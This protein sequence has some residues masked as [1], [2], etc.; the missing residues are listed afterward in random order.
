MALLAVLEFGDN[1]TKRYYKQYLLTDLR[2]MFNR[3]YNVIP[4]GKIRCEG[5]E[6]TVVA[7]Y[8]NDLS[9]FEWFL[10]NSTHSGRIVISLTGDSTDSESKA[11]EIYFEDAKCASLSEKYQVDN[12]RNR[13]LKVSIVSEK[14][15]MG[16]VTFKCL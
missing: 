4:T 14:I 2:L 10:Q 3:S 9:M 1:S 6:I 8:K 15:E 13:Q 12:L 5:M 11:Q 16:S 7:P